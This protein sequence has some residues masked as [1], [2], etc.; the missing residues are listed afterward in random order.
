M[1][2]TVKFSVVQDCKRLYKIQRIFLLLFICGQ[3]REGGPRGGIFSFGSMNKAS[4]QFVRLCCL[5]SPREIFKVVERMSD[6]LATDLKGRQVCRNSIL[7]SQSH[8]NRTPSL[9]QMKISVKIFY[10]FTKRFKLLILNIIVN[11]PFILNIY[12]SK[13]FSFSKFINGNVA[14]IIF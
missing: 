9:I 4:Q 11:Y 7:C 2:Y 10:K 13:Y 1:M 6:N 12:V 8:N 5:T 3:K 14:N